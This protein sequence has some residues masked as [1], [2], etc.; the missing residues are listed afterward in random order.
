[1]AHSFTREPV[2]ARIVVDF[3]GG[4]EVKTS[5]TPFGRNGLE[6]HD[7]VTAAQDA[8]RQLGIRTPRKNPQP[9]KV[10]VFTQRLERGDIKETPHKLEVVPYL[11]RMTDTEYKEEMDELLKPLPPEFHAFVR[12]Q[13]YDQGHSSGY[14]E[15]VSIAQGLVHDLEPCVM[16]YTKRL[17]RKPE[18]KT[19]PF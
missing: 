14:E 5:I 6:H 8:V 11:E 18:V 9:V 16:A 10:T 19:E 4:K 1:M 3:D 12:G 13:A 7:I 17:N 15:V 2:S